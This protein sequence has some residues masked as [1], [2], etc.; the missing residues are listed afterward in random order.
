MSFR[1]LITA[2]IALGIWLSSLLSPLPAL[3]L[4]QVRLFDLSYG[5][6]PP[7]L[8]E[9]A[10]ISYEGSLEANCYLIRGKAENT[11]GKPVINADVFG[12]IYDA[13]NDPV[14]QNRN[15][16]GSIDDIPPGISEFEIRVSVAVSQPPPLR[17]EHFKA[18]GFTGKVRR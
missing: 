4:T 16:L 14:L 18:A 15:R 8:A 6:C 11:S 7:E 2:L 5:D 13:N 17:L 3:A 12:R 9:G 10:V 1:T